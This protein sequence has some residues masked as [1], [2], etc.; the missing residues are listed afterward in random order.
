MLCQR[1][2]LNE[3]TVHLNDLI[4]SNTQIHLC[5]KCAI[6]LSSRS[7]YHFFSNKLQKMIPI[8]YESE[9]SFENSGKRCKT[10]G[11]TFVNYKKTGKLSCSDCYED[12]KDLID[13][14]M[15]TV[16]G[17]KKY[18]GKHPK[19]NLLNKASEYLDNLKPKNTENINNFKKQLKKA[20]LE[21]RYEDAAFLRDKINSF[22]NVKKI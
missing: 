7:N 16:F 6:D 3:A 10:C 13:Q 22:Q 20:V 15:I 8:E 17:K 21:E 4:D 1:C 5:E 19:Y 9:F 18:I 11:N 2:G 12:H 14:V